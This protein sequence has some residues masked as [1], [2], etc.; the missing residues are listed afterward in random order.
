MSV[1]I[2]DTDLGYEDIIQ[3]IIDENDK[4]VEVGFYN[5][6][7][8]GGIGLGELAATHEF[9]AGVPKRPFMRRSFDNG[10]KDLF[11][12]Q[13]E[14]IS[15]MIDGNIDKEQVLEITG[16]F[17]K[18]QIQNG[19]VQRTLGLA[20]NAQVTI[21]RKGS[22]TPLIDTARLINGAKSNVVKKNG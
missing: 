21:D 14:L 8:A 20:P 1:E 15:S 9:G 11:N 13:K 6:E 4:E 12:M 18:N 7:S 3:A 19:V 22:D 2:I 5:E 16:D 17:H 10:V